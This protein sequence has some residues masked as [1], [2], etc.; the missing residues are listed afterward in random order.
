[1]KFRLQFPSKYNLNKIYFLS[2]LFSP[3]V[4]R[5]LIPYP[6]KLVFVVNRR[7]NSRCQMC[8]IWKEKN[9][10]FLSIKQIEKIFSNNRFS[11]IKQITFTGGEPTLRNDL[12][13]IFE[14]CIRSLEN[15]ETVHFTTS[16]LNTKRTLDQI[17]RLAVLLPRLNPNVSSLSIQIS[18]DGIGTTHDLIRGISGFFNKTDETLKGLINLQKIYQYLKIRIV[19]VVMPQNLSDLKLIIEYANNN[20]LEVAFSPVV[21]SNEFFHNIDDQERLSLNS[22]HYQKQ[23]SNFFQDI[24][25]NT[26]SS[27]RYY[28]KDIVKMLNG[29]IRGRRCLMGFYAFA[30]EHDGNVYPC[31]FCQKNSF[32]NLLEQ[33]FEEIWFKDINKNVRNQ[34]RTECCSNCPA[35]CYTLP[36]DY[37]ELSDLIF[38]NFFQKITK[39]KT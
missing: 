15:L 6:W 19:T 3:F 11:F 27:L 21:F 22:S 33:S 31:Q 38:R 18:L 8:N 24:S 20:N 37:F 4:E 9:S 16:G 34:M 26:A 29:N 10:T 35:M 13:D 1:M 23:A 17:E 25:N 5:Y 28:Y 12:V 7:C 2:S 39:K 30:L 32:G 36:I 14:I